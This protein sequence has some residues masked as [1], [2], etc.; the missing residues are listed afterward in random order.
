MCISDHSIKKKRKESKMSLEESNRALVPRAANPVALPNNDAVFQ[1]NL[2]A[3]TDYFTRNADK[4]IFQN[5]PQHAAGR[6]EFSN[7]ER[8]IRQYRPTTVTEI[9]AQHVL[10]L[11]KIAPEACIQFECMARGC[12]INAFFAT[13]QP[14]SSSQPFVTTEN[15]I[16]MKCPQLSSGKTPDLGANFARPTS[17]SVRSTSTCTINR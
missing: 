13:H 2:K 4:I 11:T 16:S 8:F 6:F 7:L 3:M 5:M 1:Q 15:S 12:S 14:R 17:A 10:W 9:T